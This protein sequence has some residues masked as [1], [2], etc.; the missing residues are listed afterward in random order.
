VNREIFTVEEENLICVYDF[1]GRTALITE[2]RAAMP[3]FD[4]P[5]MRE[6]AENTLKKLDR[7]TDA[8]FS[9][10]TF[11]PAYSDDDDERQV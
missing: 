9:A 8:A 7:M 10:L 4:E 11:C 5:E 6:T 2:L 1:S 3:R